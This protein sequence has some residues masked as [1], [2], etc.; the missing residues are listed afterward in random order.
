MVLP[1]CRLPEA[2]ILQV[3][4]IAVRRAIDHDHPNTGMYYLLT[5]LTF[6]YL[7]NCYS[8]FSS[9]ARSLTKGEFLKVY[10][11]MFLCRCIQ[12]MC[13]NPIYP[14]MP[15]LAMSPEN[16]SCFGLILDRGGGAIVTIFSVR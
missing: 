15:Y 10:L 1:S 5:T 14:A 2:P 16:S 4:A 3:S 13:T 6:L 7:F 8:M 9:S 11:V 12:T